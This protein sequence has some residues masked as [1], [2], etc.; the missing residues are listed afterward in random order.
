MG[1]FT[2]FL[3][4]KFKK[5][6]HWNVSESLFFSNSS[7]SQCIQRRVITHFEVLLSRDPLIM[8]QR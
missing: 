7:G 6:T 1:L 8:Y 3:L 4:D 5:L 2:W